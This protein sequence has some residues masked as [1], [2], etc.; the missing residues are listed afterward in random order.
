MRMKT[1]GC[2]GHGIS[3]TLT[4]S[5]LSSSEKIK[6]WSHCHGVHDASNKEV[7]RHDKQQNYDFYAS[8]VVC[9]CVCVLWL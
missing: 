2:S 9:M 6:I 5:Q 8:W 1:P 7:A 4:A 3:H